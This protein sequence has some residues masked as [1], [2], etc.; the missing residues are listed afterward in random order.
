M[1]HT[2]YKQEYAFKGCIQ[3]VKAGHWPQFTDR[4][5]FCRLMRPSFEDI[6]GMDKSKNCYV[7]CVLVNKATIK[8]KYVSFN[9]KQK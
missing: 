4:A 7:V 1:L 8:P 6:Y 2:N 3:T 9:R 5:A